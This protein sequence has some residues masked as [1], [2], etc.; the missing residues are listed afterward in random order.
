MLSKPGIEIF[1]GCTDAETSVDCLM[2]I[3]CGILAVLKAIWFRVY[4]KNL[5]NNYNCV[6]K[7]YLTIENT[8]E[9]AIM[10]KHTFMGRTLCCLILSFAYFSSVMYGVIA[11][12]DE[13]KYVNITNEDIMLQ[14]PIP[15]KCFMKYLNAPVSMHKLFCLIDVIALILASTSNHGNDALFLNVTLHICGQM[16]ILRANF[17]E[18]DI[19][20]PHIYNRFNVLIERHKYLI[21]LARELAEMISSVLLIELFIISLL[22]CLMGFQLILQLNENNIGLVTRNVMAQSAFLTQ[23]TLYCFI[24]NYL[25]SEMEEIGISIYQST[26]Y[27]FPAKLKRHIVFVIMRSD[28]PVVLQA[29]NFIVVNLATYMNILKAS[30]SYLS[31]LRVTVN[32]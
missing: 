16:K 2:L 15:S 11:I 8:K 22:L 4:A 12:L 25:K 3:S 26:W 28:T 23:L 13:K 17:I 7:D 6:V 27:S 1:M 30:L 5:A 9:R 19:K 24:G 31:V 18:F 10:R 29:G 20:S 32:V 14:Y 21:K